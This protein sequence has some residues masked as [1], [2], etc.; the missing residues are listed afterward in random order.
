MPEEYFITTLGEET[1]RRNK[2]FQSG[3]EQKYK[4]PWT[5][6]D[7]DRE[8]LAIFKIDGEPRKT[9]RAWIEKL[10]AELASVMGLPTA[11]Y[12]MCK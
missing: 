9:S 12:Y 11:A 3:A 4:I 10:S 8:Q 7:P 5:Q 2:K 1:L 6:V